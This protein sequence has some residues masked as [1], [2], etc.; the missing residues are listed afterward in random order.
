MASVATASSMTI[1][2]VLGT[3]ATVARTSQRVVETAASGLDMLDTYVATARVNQVAKHKIVNDDFLT[4]LLLE[5]GLEQA[6][7]EQAIAKQLV[8]TDLKQRFDTIHARYSALFATE[9]PA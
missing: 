3:I 1:T 5:S 2:S 6:K 9:T 7:R 8:D 4:N